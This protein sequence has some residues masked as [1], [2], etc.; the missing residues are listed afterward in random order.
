[1]GF[2]S[3]TLLRVLAGVAFVLAIGAV[4]LGLWVD[5]AVSVFVG[6]AFGLASRERAGRR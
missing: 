1:M 4:I 2:G 6:A 3:P 5:F